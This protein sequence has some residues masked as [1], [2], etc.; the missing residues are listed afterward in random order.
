M[1]GT[2]YIKTA[3]LM[4]LMGAVL[5][6]IF[7]LAG[8][9][10][11]SG[12]TGAIIG[13]A[14]LGFIIA[15]A[16]NFIMYWFSDKMVIRATHAKP[17][18]PVKYRRLHEMVER[19]SNNA[20]IPKPDVYV[21]NRRDPNAFATGRGP[22][23]AVV[24]VHTGLLDM[25]SDQEVEGVLAH[26]ITHVKNRDI[27]IS[28]IAAVFA[29]LISYSY[30]LFWI[31]SD[32]RGM[33][34]L[35]GMLIAMIA[36]PI[37]AALIQMA[38]SRT[39]EYAADAGGAEISNPL[40]LA[41]ALEKLGGIT[42]Q[43]PERSGESEKAMSHMYISNPFGGSVKSLFSTHPPMEERVRRLRAMRR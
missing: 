13:F 16:M 2:N 28:T 37:I 7:A 12:S 30:I 3:M 42:V 36:A 32:R 23:H 33:L 35:A 21:V 4:A 41:S 31:V 8:W 17:A 39:R 26:E 25:M 22:G 19:L 11:G 27:L 38:I 14:T 34:G 18:D 40:H 15:I 1:A 24:A 6:G 10:S 43:Y 29:M 9:W 5:I 20:R